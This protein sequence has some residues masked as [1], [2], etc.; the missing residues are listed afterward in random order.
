MGLRGPGRFPVAVFV[1][2]D[3]PDRGECEGK[4]DEATAEAGP[5]GVL[6]DVS[7]VLSS[8]ECDGIVGTEGA[9]RGHCF[10]SSESSGTSSIFL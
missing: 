7:A 2:T 6:D 3:G 4:A 8:F 5:G 10:A 1:G 9:Q